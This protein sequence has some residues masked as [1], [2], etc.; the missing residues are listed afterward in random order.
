MSS[1]DQFK[2]KLDELSQRFNLVLEGW[3][4]NYVAY[5]TFPG[6]QENKNLF[7][8]EQSNLD[9]TNSQ[10]FLLKNNIE[11]SSKSLNETIQKKDR[12]INR[13]KSQNASLSN[14]AQS[15]EGSDLASAEM[16]KNFGTEYKMALSSLVTHSLGVALILFIFHRYH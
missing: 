14:K 9:E 10:L 12:T 8:R 11:E 4:R 13:L 3:E 1:P 5:K 16:V 7:Q 15:I 2:K 6:Y